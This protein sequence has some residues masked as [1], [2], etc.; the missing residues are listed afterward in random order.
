MQGSLL[1]LKHLKS[2]HF[3]L[4]RCLFAKYVYKQINFCITKEGIVHPNQ[5]SLF[6]LEST[7]GYFSFFCLLSTDS[8]CLINV[9]F[10]MLERTCLHTQFIYFLNFHYL[11]LFLVI[12]FSFLSLRFHFVKKVVRFF[13]SNVIVLLA[14]T[15]TLYH[16]FNQL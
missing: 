12:L 15:K 3:G 7:E 5:T 13:F 2:T 10:G 8:F 11:M 4:W 6:L 1:I 14:S 16:M 9:S